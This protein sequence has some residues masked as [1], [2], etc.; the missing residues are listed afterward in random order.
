MAF[1]DHR[2]ALVTGAAGGI[3]QA[4]VEML[5]A[6]ALTVYALGRDAAQLG[7]LCART[8]AV[9][10]QIDLSDPVQIEKLAQLEIDILVNNAGVSFG[11]VL[12]SGPASAVDDQIDVNLRA[13]LH[14]IRLFLPSM[15]KQ[16]LG[17]IVNITSL[18]SEHTYDGHAAYHATKAGMHM[19]S[20]QIRNECFGTAVR[21][22]EVS[23]GRVETQI[24]SKAQGLHPSEASAR[25]F[26]GYNV[27]QP[28]DI[29]DAVAFAI[30]APAHVN[31][32]HIELTPT[33][34]VAGGLRIA[35]WPA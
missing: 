33:M 12:S 1:T 17:H 26:E 8:G 19:A 4:L 11:G 22:T 32:G 24:F 14:L 29:A 27:L 16:K 18:A 7:E 31:I 28:Q 35:K 6:Q 3:G 15:I 25:Y 9:V 21:I 2:T 13:P 23:P 34:Q 20:M 30:D 5:R 10:L